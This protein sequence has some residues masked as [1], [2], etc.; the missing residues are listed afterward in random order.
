MMR[1]HLGLL[2]LFAAVVALGAC[3]GSPASAGPS[4]TAGSMTAAQL[5]LALIDQLGPRWY[6]DPDQFPVARA[7]EQQRAIE[8]FPDMQAEGAVFRAIAARLRLDPDGP[9]TDAQKLAIY[10]LWKVATSIPFDPRGD[11]SY[12]FDYVARPVGGAANGVHT[13]GTIDAAGTITITRQEAAGQPVCPICLAVGTPIDTPL[14]AVPIERLRLGDPV[15]TLDAEGARVPGTIVAIGSTA[16]PPGHLV[17]RLTLADGRT[18][19]ASPGHPLADGRRVGELTVGDRVD[20]STVA[21]VE[22]VP[23]PGPETHDI[24]VSGDTGVYLAGGVPL[25]STLVGPALVAGPITP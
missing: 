2:L 9:L 15:W 16:A 11:G 10:A 1:R 18:V 21:S 7:D 19:L 13:V 24:A 12:A 3:G 5:R 17:V 14:G 25:R 23:D 8:R 22:R 6:C 20:G 4:A